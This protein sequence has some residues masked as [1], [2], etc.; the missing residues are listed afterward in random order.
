MSTNA[1]NA[2]APWYLYPV[3]KQFNGGSEKGVDLGVPYHTPVTPLFPGVVSAVDTGPYGQEVDVRGL[4][5]GQ[6]VTAS[7]VHLDQALVGVGQPVTQ[8]SE[9][10]VS[11]GQLSGGAHPASPAYSSGPHIEFSLWPSGTTPYVGTPYNPMSFIQSVQGSQGANVLNALGGASGATD[12]TLATLQ[13]IQ[14]I[15]GGGLFGGALS[16]RAQGSP[17]I[18]IQAPD[19]AGGVTSAANNIG[20]NALAALHLSSF[21]DL[22][23]RAGLLLVALVLVIVIAQALSMKATEGV[24]ADIISSPPVQAA[25]KAVR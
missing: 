15:I 6:P 24:S 11:G 8:G 23:W 19:I 12:S 16:G 22:L 14:S 13:S 21:S 18:N 2:A 5:N 25:A 20:R 3:T 10:G 17:I 7:Y 1:T 4:L 9:L